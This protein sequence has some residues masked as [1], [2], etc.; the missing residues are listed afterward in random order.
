VSYQQRRL[1]PALV[2]NSRNSGKQEVK[3]EKE[4][5]DKLLAIFVRSNSF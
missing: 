1:L 4:T 2:S 3:E 5:E